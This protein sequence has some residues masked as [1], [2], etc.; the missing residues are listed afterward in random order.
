MT[1]IDNSAALSRG[2]PAETVAKLSVES[3][4]APM[5]LASMVL[6]FGTWQFAV[7][8]LEVQSFILPTPSAIAAQAWVDVS[9]GFI[10]PHFTRTF[11]EVAFGFVISVTVATI[12]GTIIALNRA[13]EI[14]FYPYI[15]IIQTVPKV[16]IAPLFV[17]WFGFGIESKVV[18]AAMI[19][20]FPML[21]NIIAGL[22]SADERRLLLM[23]AYRAGPMKTYLSV[24]VPS[25]LPYMF[26]GMETGIIFA[27][28][29]AI[30]GEFIGASSGLGALIV[31]RQAAMDTAGVFSALIFL[32]TMGLVLN[33]AVRTLKARFVYWT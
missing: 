2:S 27:T 20:F 11:T 26:A 21:V 7:W 22:K 9:T 4:K 13:A 32:S 16:A 33:G 29:G 25:M 31:Q 10:W 17:I 18:T 30:V 5:V 14:L 3:F 1:A 24:R 8:A 15:L 28:L 19:A 23:R 6:F 12:L